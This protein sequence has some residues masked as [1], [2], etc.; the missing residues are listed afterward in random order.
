MLLFS[1]IILWSCEETE[2]INETG[3]MQVTDFNLP[4]LPEGYYYEGW[5]LVDGSYVSV[6]NITNDSITNGVA[7]FSSIEVT[8]LNTAQ[9][10]AI[11]VE[12]SGS[13]APSNY[14]LLV[15]NFDGSTANLTSSGE[16]VNGIMSLANRISA[17]YT[18]QNASV[19]ETEADNYGT[20]GIWFF[21]GTGDLKEPILQ[22][23]YDD[24]SYQ[25][26]A[27]K[28]YENVNYQLNMG[29]IVSDTINDSYK[30]FS[31]ANSVPEFPGE[32]FLQDPAGEPDYP[33]NFFPMDVRGSKVFI[34]PI[35]VNYN[36]PET[37]FPIKLWE[38]TVPLDAVKDPNLTRDFQVN[39]GYAA[40]ATKL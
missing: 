11:T 7:R 14:V 9:S 17:S 23:D 24:L 19:P 37:P 38:A 39:T 26:W 18:V 28:S 16:T 2:I 36:N 6:G 15:G 4:T 5:L 25:A 1:G 33:E 29:V 22:L 30:G 27:E 3:K 20:N 10:F 8:D 40:I 34:T 32:D 35:P 31:Y 13:A 12:T 21:K